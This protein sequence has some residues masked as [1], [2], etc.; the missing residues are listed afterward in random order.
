M[1]SGNNSHQRRWRHRPIKGLVVLAALVFVA[2]AIGS[3]GSQATVAAKLY[4]KK[5]GWSVVCDGRPMPVLTCTFFDPRAKGTATVA[6]KSVALKGQFEL[7]G[8]Q[9]GHPCI[10]A[11]TTGGGTFTTPATTVMLNVCRADWTRTLT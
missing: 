10:Y 1:R 9:P 7:S 8:P 3:V 6:G 5:M 2:P 4:A 11:V